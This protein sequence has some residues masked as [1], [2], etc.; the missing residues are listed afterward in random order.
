MIQPPFPLHWEHNRVTLHF[1]PQKPWSEKTRNTTVRR[2]H[3]LG[4]VSA[5]ARGKGEGDK[6][7]ASKHARNG[8]KS[9][10]CR[11]AS[12]SAK[13]LVDATY[14]CEGQLHKV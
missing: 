5:C 6:Q 2:D 9:Q 4:Q 11:G 8:Q 12:D 14:G 10:L 13:N 3:L 7:V 1:R